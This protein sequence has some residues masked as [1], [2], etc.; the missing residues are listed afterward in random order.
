MVLGLITRASVAT[1]LSMY[2]CIFRCLWVNTTKPCDVTMPALLSNVALDVVII[3]TS[4]AAIDNNGDILATHFFVN[5]TVKWQ[6]LF[7][8]I[9]V[10]CIYIAYFFHI[11]VICKIDYWVNWILLLKWYLLFLSHEW[12]QNQLTKK[13]HSSGSQQFTR[14]CFACLY[15]K[16]MNLNWSIKLAV[17]VF[18]WDPPQA[19]TYI[20][21][22][23]GMYFNVLMLFSWN[24]GWQTPKTVW[25]CFLQIW[26]K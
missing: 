24:A 15:K 4:S 13:L 21:L 8:C 11:N 7:L 18:Q 17:M 3:V 2:A 16:C 5:R 22:L 25:F 10:V 12:Y 20:Y 23:K 14:V 19:T 26:L 9:D 1:V 6:W